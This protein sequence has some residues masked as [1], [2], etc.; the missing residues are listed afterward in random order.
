MRL[1]VS[2][3]VSAGLAFMANDVYATKL[4]THL[5]SAGQQGRLGFYETTFVILCFATCFC[6]ALSYQ[7]GLLFKLLSTSC[8]LMLAVFTF[9][10]F[11]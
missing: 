6:F 3:V 9:I 10:S 7:A 8:F 2:L 1:L 5:E 4:Q 11:R